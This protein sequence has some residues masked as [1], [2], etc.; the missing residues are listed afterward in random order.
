MVVIIWV[1]ITGFGL[2]FVNI[3]AKKKYRKINHLILLTFYPL[4]ILTNQGL[5]FF[6]NFYSKINSLKLSGIVDKK[7]NFPTQLV[8]ITNRIVPLFLVP[9][10]SAA[11]LSF[12]LVRKV[13][14]PYDDVNDLAEDETIELGIYFN[15]GWVIVRFN[16][17]LL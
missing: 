3:C 11:I 12:L 15:G 1:V 9:A 6:L 4:Q 7:E 13:K 10:Y 2:I 17:I 16:T 5:C 8:L 14:L